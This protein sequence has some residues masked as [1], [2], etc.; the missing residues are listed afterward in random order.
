MVYSLCL[1]IL[2]KSSFRSK[3]LRQKQIF[4]TYTSAIH[5]FEHSSAEI[6]PH[7]YSK[8]I[9]SDTTLVPIKLTPNEELKILDLRGK[10]NWDSRFNK[11]DPAEAT[12][13]ESDPEGPVA[14]GAIAQIM[15][16]GRKEKLKAE[17]IRAAYSQCLDKNRCGYNA[18]VSRKRKAAGIEVAAKYEPSETMNWMTGK[19]RPISDIHKQ[20]P[21]GQW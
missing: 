7:A 12:I 2:S 20:K 17:D 9:M 5:L 16:R 4:Q 6:N 1:L 19:C 8:I 10:K 21:K 15:S 13:D 3:H 14:F 18:V 11:A